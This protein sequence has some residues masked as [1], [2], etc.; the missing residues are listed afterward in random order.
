M[1]KQVI[2]VLRLQLAGSLLI[3]TLRLRRTFVSTR[4]SSSQ[5]SLA[6]ANHAIPLKHSSSEPRWH[7]SSIRSA[8]CTGQHRNAKNC[9]LQFQLLVSIDFLL[10]NFGSLLQNLM[11]SL[12]EH[13]ETKSYL[14]GTQAF[15]HDSQNKLDA[16]PRRQS[17]STRSI[18][19]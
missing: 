13:Y 2:M 1:Q 15:R 16:G 8:L 3:C 6:T 17:K 12:S 7:A 5:R 4:Y 19:S 10:T 11:C 9:Q 18:R 14:D